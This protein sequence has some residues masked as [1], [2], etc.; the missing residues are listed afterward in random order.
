MKL[1]M[2]GVLSVRARFFPQAS[3][4]HTN[5]QKD[6]RDVEEGGGLRD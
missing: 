1:L 2:S 6:P 3:M 5:L 4:S